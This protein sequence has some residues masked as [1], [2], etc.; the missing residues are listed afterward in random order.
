LYALHG[1]VY[2]A[3]LRLKL[4]IT[5]FRSDFTEGHPFRSVCSSSLVNSFALLEDDVPLNADI[6]F[7]QVDI[8][9]KPTMTPASLKSKLLELPH[10]ERDANG[11]PRK[12]LYRSKNRMKA[13]G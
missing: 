11:I 1:S 5:R 3:H 9:Y 7:L 4:M 13:E 10:S 6:A 8:V 12:L 2:V